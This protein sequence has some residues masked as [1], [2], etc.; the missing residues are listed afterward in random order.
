MKNPVNISKEILHIYEN[1]P[2][3][4]NFT[5][6]CRNPGDDKIRSSDQTFEK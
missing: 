4:W 6:C 3:F 2:P 1:N 5:I